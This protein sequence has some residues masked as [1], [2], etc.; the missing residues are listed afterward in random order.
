MHQ[1]V[2]PVREFVEP[3]MSQLNLSKRLYV[4]VTPDEG[5]VWHRFADIHGLSTA[6]FIRLAVRLVMLNPHLLETILKEEQ[7]DEHR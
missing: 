6:K 2:N 5:V 7:A 1:L 3:Y 4:Q